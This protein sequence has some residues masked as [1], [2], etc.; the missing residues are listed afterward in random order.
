MKKLE[1][2]VFII[3]ARLNSTRLPNKMLKP[4]AGTS[5]L[6]ISVD[7]VKQSVIPKENFY[8]SI[9]DRELMEFASKNEVNIYER[10]ETSVSNRKILSLSE[11]WDW[12]DKLPFKYFILLNAC[13]PLLTFTTINKFVESFRCTRGGLLSVFEHKKW[14]YT[15]SGNFP[16]ENLGDQHALT[17]FNSQ[18]V[19]PLYSNGP[20]KGG[21][22]SDIGKEIHVCDFESPPPVFK[23]PMEEHYDIDTEE[24][25]V[26]GEN[27]YK[28]SRLKN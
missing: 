24:D 16:Q 25:F 5:L 10:P 21:L 8:L 22:M 20:I 7:Q 3:Q 23:Y 14:F 17:T 12:W 1:D 15:P 13:N 11:T 18:W 26:I 27:L 4:F 19:E 9:R 28:A 2:I 6:Q